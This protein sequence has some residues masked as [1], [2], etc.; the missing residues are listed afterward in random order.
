MNTNSTNIEQL[1]R[2]F[3][4]DA[5]TGIVTRNAGK[6]GNSWADT[7]GYL[8]IRFVNKQFAVHRIAWA[9]HYGEWP[10]Q[11]IDH[12]NGIKNDNRISN[13]RDV[14]NATNA[15][16]R[17]SANRNGSTGLLGVTWSKEKRRFIAHVKVNGKTKKLGRFLNAREAFDA[18]MKYR[19]DLRE[20]LGA[21]RH[22]K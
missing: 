13:L 5:A 22:D 19:E 1:R 12:I 21:R 17:H 16:N 15:V 2:E 11:S 10:Q 7:K 6:G 14:S 4:Y 3:S 8:R 18:S 9:L 20:Q